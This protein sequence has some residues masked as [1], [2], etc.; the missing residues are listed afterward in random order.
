MPH[1]N[2]RVGYLNIPSHSITAEPE[3]HPFTRPD[4]DVIAI[5]EL[6]DNQ[7]TMH[8][9]TAEGARALADVFTRAALLIE[10]VD[11]GWIS[12]TSGAEEIPRPDMPMTGDLLREMYPDWTITRDDS[13]GAWT[14]ERLDGTEVR[15]L[16]AVEAWQLGL[17]I[18]AAEQAPGH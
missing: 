4:G 15:F 14:A 3:V 16:A 5:V 11:H 8:V 13:L 9:E 10:G 1:P 17:K 7:L 12:G 6:G 18:R 2:D